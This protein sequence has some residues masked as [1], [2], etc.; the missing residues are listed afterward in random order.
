MGLAAAAEPV[1]ATL[2]IA[3]LIVRGFIVLLLPIASDAS[4]LRGEV[5]RSTLG[6]LER[7]LG[8]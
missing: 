5:H 8:I 2:R 7:A 3:A 4:V 1:S 6:L